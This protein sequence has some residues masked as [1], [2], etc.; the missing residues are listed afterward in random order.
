MKIKDKK[1]LLKDLVIPKGTIFNKAPEQ[2]SHGE[3]SFQ[4][5]FGLSKN[6]FGAITYCVDTDFIE[7]LDDWFTDLK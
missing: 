1:V 5:D 7:E 4:A 3:D 6:T 2:E